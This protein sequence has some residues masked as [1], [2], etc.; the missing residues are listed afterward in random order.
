MNLQ[1]FSSSLITTPSEGKSFMNIIMG[2][3]LSGDNVLDALISLYE[4]F[5]EQVKANDK[6]FAATFFNMFCKY[7]MQSM[8]LPYYEK[9]SKVWGASEI[10]TIKKQYAELLQNDAKQTFKNSLEFS[11]A[12]SS[13]SFKNSPKEAFDFIENHLDVLEPI[14]KKN[15]AKFIE[16]LVKHH[17]WEGLIQTNY[18][19]FKILCSNLKINHVDVLQQEYSTSFYG[20]KYLVSRTSDSG[21]LSILKDIKDVPEFFNGSGFFTP[22]NRRTPEIKNQ[23]N[24]LEVAL[25][26]LAESKSSSFHH[27]FTTY[28]DEI[29]KCMQCYLYDQHQTADIFNHEHWNTLLENMLESSKNYYNGEAF[30]EHEMKIIKDKIKG[31]FKVIDA[32]ILE[33]VLAIKEEIKPRK[34][35]I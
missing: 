17:C 7:E 34:M 27:L 12:L 6:A 9:F 10:A 11:K 32:I 35:K 1:Q 22:K 3:S 2:M 18:S 4:S 19:R 29:K 8:H 28:P 25:G 13:A 23:V 20:F 21:F 14:I 24:V 26:L 30:P 16:N 31:N 15:A 5:P 33:H